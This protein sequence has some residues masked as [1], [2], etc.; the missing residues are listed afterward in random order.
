VYVTAL[1]FIWAFVTNLVDSTY[2]EH[3]ADLSAEPVRGHAQPVRIL[4][5]L[6]R[7]VAPS[8]VGIV[9]IRLCLVIITG[10]LCIVIGC[11]V[12]WST[13]FFNA[14]GIVL[15]GLFVAA[16]GGTLLQVAANPLI[17]SMGDVKRSHFRLNLHKP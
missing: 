10:L 6:F 5:G 4:L 9:Q 14:F 17:A 11:V 13:L 15:I 7:D 1:F 8:G 3:E 12:A 16:S 2:Q